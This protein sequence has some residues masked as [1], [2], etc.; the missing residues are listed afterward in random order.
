MK[1]I[2]IKVHSFVDLITNSSSE[3]FIHATQNVIDSVYEFA[4]FI[5]K[6][7]EKTSHLKATDVFSI[8]YAAEN[9]DGDLI[10]EIKQNFEGDEEIKKVL[11]KISELVHSYDIDAYYNG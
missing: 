2:H 7:D 3:V 9:D 1:N 11:T 6:K 8:E 5:L 10:I 4:D